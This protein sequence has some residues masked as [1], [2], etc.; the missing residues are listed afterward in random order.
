MNS[1]TVLG[2]DMSKKTFDVALLRDSKLKHKKFSNNVKGFQALLAWLA[3]HQA[4]AAHVCLEATG[5]YGGE[6]GQVGNGVRS[7]IYDLASIFFQNPK[8]KT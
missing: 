7:L 2:V 1:T 8:L 5:V 4:K 6:W 3:H